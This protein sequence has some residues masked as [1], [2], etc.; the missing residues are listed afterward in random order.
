MA[1]K[2]ESETS[3]APIGTEYTMPDENPTLPQSAHKCRVTQVTGE[4]PPMSP[5]FT[6]HS[7]LPKPLPRSR[8]GLQQGTC[9]AFAMGMARVTDATGIG[10]RNSKSLLALLGTGNCYRLY[11]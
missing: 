6:R 1:A 4:Q 8:L 2:A 11:P 9:A 5:A 10:T 3:L 7:P